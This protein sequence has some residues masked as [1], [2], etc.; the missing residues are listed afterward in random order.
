M[1][2]QNE[3]LG[4]P[5]SEN[6]TNV[7]RVPSKAFFSKEFFLLFSGGKPY[8]YKENPVAQIIR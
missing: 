8:N 5:I 3:N 4:R 7:E 2:F 1:H 6:R